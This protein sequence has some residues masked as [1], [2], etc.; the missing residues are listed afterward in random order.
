LTTA[1]EFGIAGLLGWPVAHSRSPVIHNHWLAQFGISGRYVTFAVPPEKLEQA[2]RGIQVLGLRGC[3]V[4]TP[5]KQ[6]I[7][8]LLDRVDDLA[9]RIGAVQTVVVEKDGSLSGFNNDGN[10]FIQSLRDAAPG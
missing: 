6:A 9:R 8:P 7:F 10:G 5:H 1:H 4:T 3:N 2:V